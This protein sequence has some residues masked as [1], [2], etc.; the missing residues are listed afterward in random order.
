MWSEMSCSWRESIAP[1][2][3]VN[4]MVSYPVNNWCKWSMGDY[5]ESLHRLKFRLCSRDMYGFKSE[6]F[7]LF[8]SFFQ[9]CHRFDNTGERYLSEKKGMVEWFFL[10]DLHGKKKCLL[11]DNQILKIKCHRIIIFVRMHY[12]L[13]LCTMKYII[14]N[15]PHRAQVSF[16][17]LRFCPDL[18]L[19][20][21]DFW[22]HRYR[23]A[24]AVSI[25]LFY[26]RQ[27][28]W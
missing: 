6:F 1:Y 15:S 21:D 20:F 7:C 18:R 2:L 3:S 25:Q 14:I 17:G 5:R 19:L 26:R 27:V 4:L 9:L 8:Q 11:P 23:F 24:W 13:I 16:W 10:I 12:A 22:A 28:F